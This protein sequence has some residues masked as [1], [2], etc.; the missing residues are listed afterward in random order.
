MNASTE[1]G[2]PD[3]DRI[4]SIGR[5]RRH[6]HPKPGELGGC[7]FVEGVGRNNEAHLVG[8]VVL[9]SKALTE[10]DVDQSVGTLLGEEEAEL[11]NRS[12]RGRGTQLNPGPLPIATI[13]AWPQTGTKSPA[14]SMAV[15][16]PT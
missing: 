2:K 7:R 10:S 9:T 11:M 1:I 6:L 8:S 12:P 4:I 5:R 3:G 14:P 16:P 15:V 13:P